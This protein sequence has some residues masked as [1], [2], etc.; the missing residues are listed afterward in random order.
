MR[1]DP[2]LRPM[3]SLKVSIIT[4]T[5]NSAKTVG[6]TLE[7]VAQQSY[8]NIEHLIVDG[9][10]KD[11]T[12]EIVKQFPHVGAVRCE[13]DRG[14][15]DAMNKGIGMASGDVIGILNSDDIYQDSSV[16]SKVAEEFRDPTVMAVYGDL[17]YVE[18]DNLAK[19]VRNWQSGSFDR[20]KFLNGW[21]PP[22]PTFFVRREAY[23]SCGTFDLEF[24]SAADY[25]LMLRFLYKNEMSIISEV[26]F[27]DSYIWIFY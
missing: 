1:S 19:V 11:Q 13:K 8:Q 22:H 12:L 18:E 15:Y 10:S 14:I 27:N 20:K 21:M 25:E 24:K 2:Y 5:Y 3:N 9:V 4:A 23:E 16:I 7:S 17:V 26:I 6:D